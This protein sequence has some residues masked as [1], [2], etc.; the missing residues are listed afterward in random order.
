MRLSGRTLCVLFTLLLAVQGEHV[1]GAR[2]KVIVRSS[3]RSVPERAYGVCV[4]VRLSRDGVPVCVY[5]ARLTDG[6]V[7]SALTAAE[8]A[9]RGVRPLDDVL[10]GWRAC[11]FRLFLELCRP[12]AESLSDEA[13]AEREMI[14]RRADAEASAAF[15]AP[16]ACGCTELAEEALQAAYRAG[17]RQGSVWLVTDD[18]EVFDRYGGKSSRV[19]VCCLSPV[20]GARGLLLHRSRVASKSEVRSLRRGGRR[21]VVWDVNS[22]ED[23]AAMGA[24]GVDFIVTDDPASIAD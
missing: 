3:D 12:A 18:G 10:A 19:P 15:A 20:G 21:V 24:C 16:A 17:F 23:A 13:R 22:A 1:W 4:P 2:T 6:T 8:L 14:L 9:A 11:G 5:D 7:V